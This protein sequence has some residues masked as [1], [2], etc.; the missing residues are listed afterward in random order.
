MTLML[1]QYLGH[2]P[3]SFCP[4]QVFL[5]LECEDL[6][7]WLATSQVPF[8]KQ[9]KTLP[10]T[11]CSAANPQHFTLLLLKGP[12]TKVCDPKE[13]TGDLVVA[14]SPLEQGEES[15]V[16]KGQAPEAWALPGICIRGACSHWQAKVA[17]SQ[18][19]S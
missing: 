16:P 8:E 6:Q 11:S 1:F 9:I 17:G 2:T 7:G 5:E 12:Y 10:Q 15:K 13:G 14:N 4:H 19:N 18:V 3:L